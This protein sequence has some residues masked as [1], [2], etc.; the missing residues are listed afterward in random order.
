[1]NI[2][3]TLLAHPNYRLP[4][5]NVFGSFVHG[6]Q[7]TDALGMLMCIRRIYKRPHRDGLHWINVCAMPKSM[8]MLHPC[9]IHMRCSLGLSTSAGWIVR[10]TSKTNKFHRFSQAIEW[11]WTI[12]T[13]AIGHEASEFLLRSFYIFVTFPCTCVV[14]YC[15]LSILVQPKRR[16]FP[17]G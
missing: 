1:M 12:W 3:S 2:S 11:V 16:D 6:F 13:V 7:V 5:S 15:I 17:I 10:W 8:W 14:W 4:W 9:N